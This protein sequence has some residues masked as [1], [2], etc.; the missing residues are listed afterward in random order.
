M[1]WW[2]T[3]VVPAGE[4]IEDSKHAL[5]KGLE[6]V[7]SMAQSSSGD[8]VERK[9]AT[10]LVSAASN[11]LYGMCRSDAERLEAL[12]RISRVL[13]Q[14][15]SVLEGRYPADAAHWI[16]AKSY[17]A[18]TSHMRAR[19]KQRAQ[20]FMMVTADLCKSTECSAITLDMCRETAKKFSL[21]IGES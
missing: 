2:W 5:Q 9:V 6:M 13:S 16:C 17:N 15:R 19:D 3:L 18:A 4:H 20:S 8:A 11:M 14:S 12:K 10:S 7:L 1:N 21:R